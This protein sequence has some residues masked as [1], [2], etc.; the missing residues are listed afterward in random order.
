[1]AGRYILNTFILT[2][3]GVSWGSTVQCDKD[4]W[5]T[6]I[7]STSGTEI[8]YLIAPYANDTD[9][10]RIQDTTFS[11]IFLLPHCDIDVIGLSL[12]LRGVCKVKIATTGSQLEFTDAEVIVNA[13]ENENA[14]R[15]CLYFSKSSYPAINLMNISTLA[16]V[17]VNI[18]SIVSNAACVL[19][20]TA[21]EHESRAMFLHLNHSSRST[22]LKGKSLRQLS[23]C[24]KT[25]YI[26]RGGFRDGGIV[27]TM[28]PP[29]LH[30]TAFGPTDYV[31]ERTGMWVT[32]NVKDGMDSVTTPPEQQPK[33]SA[34][35]LPTV[36]GTVIGLGS[37]CFISAV[38]YTLWRRYSAQRLRGDA[39]ERQN[40]PL[41]RRPT[42]PDDLDRTA[43]LY[44]AVGPGHGSMPASVLKSST[45]QNVS[46]QAESAAYATVLDE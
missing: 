37:G 15:I 33:Q 9:L 14:E 42:T 4:G 39:I 22:R 21:R 18:T 27:P 16:T 1:M 19:A 3:F 7:Y 44:S 23:S 41:P 12:E 38:L 43:T 8:L 34:S 25:H 45:E 46:M 28:T 26:R 32:K 40:V 29:S 13:P 35:S 6:T 5:K 20:P 11:T 2:V 30:H 10:I 31:I 24:W 17:L 36:V